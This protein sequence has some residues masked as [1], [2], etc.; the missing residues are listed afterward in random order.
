MSSATKVLA[1]EDV[2]KRVRSIQK[3]AAAQGDKVTDVKD[4]TENGTVTPPTHP[5]EA[6]TNAALPGGNPK[7]DNAKP[8]DSI[9]SKQAE[10]TLE[11]ATPSTVNGTAQDAAVDS[12][13]AK[14]A[15]DAKA[16]ATRVRGLMKKAEKE[17]PATK[18]EATAADPTDK[19][20]VEP[21]KKNGPQDL[22]PASTPATAKDNGA[23]AAAAEVAANDFQLS[24]EAYI[25]LASTILE[26]EDGVVFATKLLKQA[27]GVEV[28]SQLIN[29]ALQAQENFNKAA[30]AEA[31]GAELAETMFKSASAEEQALIIKYAQVHSAAVNAIEAD[32]SLNAE[33]TQTAKLAYAQGAMDGAA[34]QDGGGELPGGTGEEPSLEDIMAV[35]EQLVQS[36]QLPPEVAQQLM[37]ELSGQGGAEGAAGEAAEAAAGTAEAADPAAAAAGVTKGASAETLL[38]A[39]ILRAQK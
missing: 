35:I 3:T 8:A 30:A 20:K 26:T 24:P 32:T 14:I 2:L 25:K 37:A 29:A 5:S 33:Q 17:E 13:T 28:A 21:T 7:A 6:T 18:S 31:Q 11:K 39:E 4:V 27:K 16:L 19:G 12:S 23:K 1:Y 36:G 15:S 22:P 9:E 10:G 38:V 34:M